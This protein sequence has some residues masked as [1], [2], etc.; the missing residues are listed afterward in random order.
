MEILEATLDDAES[1]L[2]LQRVA[3]QSEAQLHDD[4]NIPPLTQ[5]LDELKA[6]FAHKTVLKIVQ[7]GKL[8]AAGQARYDSGS[9]YIGRMAVWPDLQGQGIGSKLLTSLEN[10]F[11][12]AK[13]IELFTGEHS[14]ANLAMYNHRG[15]KEFKRALLGNTTVIF[16]ERLRDDA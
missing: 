4:F 1:I 9:C 16:L 11:P 2:A 10:V 5:T 8:L 3:Y 14:K 6:D 15:Y 12:S 13:R 7:N